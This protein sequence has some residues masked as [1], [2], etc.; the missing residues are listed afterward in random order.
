MAEKTLLLEGL[1]DDLDKIKPKLELYFRNKRRSGEE[2]REIRSH[3]TDARKALLVYLENDAWDRVLRREP[4]TVPLSDF[5][6]VQVRV[7]PLEDEAPSAKKPRCP[8]QNPPGPGTPGGKSE[9]DVRNPAVRAGSEVP[10]QPAGEAG[11]EPEEEQDGMFLVVSSREKRPLLSLYLEQFTD[12]FEIMK[13]GKNK[14]MVKFANKSDAEKILA[15]ERHDLEI[16]VE[17]Y[18]PGGAAGRLDPRRFILSGFSAD[19]KVKMFSVFIGSCSKG[20]EHTW[21]VLDEENIVVTFQRDIEIIPFLE[22]IST[23][24][25]QGQQMEVSRLELT[26]SVLVQGD[27]HKVSEDA[28]TLYFSNTKRS[29]GGSIKVINSAD[30]RMSRIVEFQHCNDAYKVAQRHHRLCETDLHAQLFYPSWQKALTGRTPTLDVPTEVAISVSEHIFEYIT[31]TKECEEDFRNSLARFHVSVSFDRRNGPSHVVL[32]SHVDPESLAA[33]MLGSSW[34]SELQREVEAL[35]GKYS[36]AQLDI[37]LDVWKMIEDE[38]AGLRH[39]DTLVNYFSNVAKVVVVGAESAVKK[40]VE[41]IKSMV[42]KASSELERERNTVQRKIPAASSEELGFIWELVHDKLKNVE[43]SKDEADLTFILKGLRHH[44]AFAED[45]LKDIQRNLICLP[46]DL[47]LHLNNF[48]N[49]FD[50]KLFERQYLTVD[51]LVVSLVEKDGGI[52]VLGQKDD[53]QRAVEI[54]KET[55]TEQTIHLTRD[56]VSLTGTACW[57][58]FLN[59]LQDKEEFC[60]A[61]VLLVDDD[62]ITVSGFSRAV[63]DVSKQLMGFFENWQYVT[64]KVPLKSV[65]EGEFFQSILSEDLD[66]LEAT[67]SCIAEFPPRLKITAPR[68]H[69][70]KAESVVKQKLASVVTEVLTYSRAGESKVLQKNQDFLQTYAKEMGCRLYLQQLQQPPSNLITPTSHAAVGAASSLGQTKVDTEVYISGVLV[71]LEKGDIT[72]TKVDILVNSTSQSLDLNTGVSGAIL[73]AAGSSVVDE[74]AK[75][76][77]QTHDAVVLTSGGNLS[78]YHIAHVVGP[79]NTSDI[80][81]STEKVLGLCEGQ[82]ASTLAFPAIGTGRGEISPEDSIR[83]ILTGLENHLSSNAPSCIKALH[84]IVYEQNVFDSYNEY[85]KKRKMNNPSSRLPSNE[86]KIG[87]I[88]IYVKKGDITQETVKGIVNSTNSDMSLRNGVSGVIFNAAGPSVEQET[89]TCGPLKG[90]DAKVTTAGNLHCD[91]ILHML[92]PHSSAEVQARVKGV[93]ELCEQKNI[94]TVSFPAVGTGGGGIKGPDAVLAMLQGFQDHSSQCANSVIKLAYIVIDRDAVF[95]EFLQGLKQWTSRKQDEDGADEEVEEENMEDDDASEEEDN[96]SSASNIDVLIG[97]L[98]VKAFCGDITQETT[99]AIVSS[100]NTSLN[101]SSGVSGAILKAAGQ[102]V[103]DECNSKGNQPSDGVVLTKAGNLATKNIVHMVGQTKEKCITSAMYKVLKLCEDNKIQSVSFPAFG[104]GAGNLG[105]AQVAQAMIDAISNFVVDCPKS[106][107]LVHIVI[108]QSKMMADFEG[109]IKNFKKITTNSSPSKRPKLT[110]PQTSPAKATQSL[111]SVSSGNLV[112]PTTLVEV[113][114]SSEDSLAQ[115][116]KILQDL[117]SEECTSKDLPSSHFCS[118]QPDDT[119]AIVDLSRS[120]EVQLLMTTP[121]TLSISGKKDDV[122]AAELKIRDLLQAAKDRVSRQKEEQRL[123]KILCWEEA[124]GESWKP[125]GSRLSY[126]L[127][128]AFQGK[129]KTFTFQQQGETRT[130]DLNKKTLTDGKGRSRNIRRTLLG[131]SDTAIVQPPPTWTLMDSKDLEIIT[132]LPTSEEYKRIEKSFLKSSMNPDPAYA[133]KFQVVEIQRIQ[134]RSQWHRYAVWKQTV[135]KR[136]PN[137]ENQRYLYHG[138][139]K[140]IAQRISMHGFNRSF[141]GRNATVHGAGTYFAKEAHYSC[142]DNYSNPDTNGLKY[143]Y[144]ARVLTGSPCK[145]RRDMKEPDPLDPS[146]PQAGLYDCAVDNLKNPFI[147]VV[148]CDAGAYP[149]YLITFKGV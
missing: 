57:D 106:V 97:P 93:L 17:P 146:N 14:W 149:D 47:S 79:R 127:E 58:D 105:A 54:T 69:M 80:T 83:A 98:K 107:T 29:G 1:P 117:I 126:N 89:K 84:L 9:R 133:Q 124:R 33:L 111:A 23:K 118:L 46:L 116:R 53:A 39:H 77:T 95:Q 141:C 82:L 147:F 28:L 134:S 44:V 35:L 8:R 10:L 86:V 40:R 61:P 18:S 138:T 114:T 140:D 101:L 74:C 68:C 112:F 102:T 43:F 67:V 7:K 87:G 37:K 91:F 45:T 115:F 85:L 41:A 144:R 38:G 113:Y 32:K 135:D 24:K 30:G 81:S 51:K 120:S 128:K 78:C 21:E 131:D 99:D 119:K 145:S 122:L 90:N 55:L 19:W 25:L 34:R 26:S 72:R 70:E 52:Q 109:A 27:M 60:H 20:A 76:G 148:F 71:V 142:H 92:G 12:R 63:G 15:K 62:V 136:H 11:P 132:L 66:E 65:K 56:Q 103:V 125:L 48:L 94:T 13:H 3:P 110:S 75:Y 139:T 5:G 31:Q 100:T 88:R 130:V 16:C 73:K 123:S 36:V 96:N 104:T 4:H 2:V 42:A 49:S 6:P 108:F 143:I 129:E 137:Q 64:E 22:K 121:E 59:V 50:L